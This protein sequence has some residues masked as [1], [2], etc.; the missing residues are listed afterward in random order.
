MKEIPILVGKGQVKMEQ[1]KIKTVKEW[2]ILMKV[3]N[4]ESFLV[5]ANFYSVM[6]RLG[7]EQF[8]FSFSFIF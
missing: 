4:I 6:G 3:K 8:L 1:E 7:H 2:K 5:F